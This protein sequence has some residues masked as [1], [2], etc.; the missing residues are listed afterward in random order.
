MQC[1]LF[2]IKLPLSFRPGI[3]GDFIVF[4]ALDDDVIPLRAEVHD[5]R[6]LLFHFGSADEGV[7]VTHQKP[8]LVVYGMDLDFG[9]LLPAMIPVQPVIYTSRERLERSGVERREWDTLRFRKFATGIPKGRKTPKA[10]RIVGAGQQGWRSQPNLKSDVFTRRL[11]P[12]D[13]RQIR[14]FRSGQ[15]KFMAARAGHLI[16]GEESLVQPV[17]QTF[18]VPQQTGQGGEVMAIRQVQRGQGQ[19]PCLEFLFKLF[20]ELSEQAAP[21]LFENLRFVEGFKFYN[22]HGVGRLGRFKLLAAN[23]LFGLAFLAPLAAKFRDL[24]LCFSWEHPTN[25]GGTSSVLPP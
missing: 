6:L 25:L 18:R 21:D 14:P 12:Q 17:W 1:E 3:G 20:E 23:S 22:R 4:R 15:Q 11:R 9:R 5:L 8:I 24:F 7:P 16:D 2:D 10:L 13:Q 19:A